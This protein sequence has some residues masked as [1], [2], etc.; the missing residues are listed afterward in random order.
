MLSPSVRDFVLYCSDNNVISFDTEK[1]YTLKSGRVAPWFFNAGNLMQHA[2]WLSKIAKIFVHTLREQFADTSGRIDA[3][4]LYGA[5]YKGVPL[6]SVVATE[7]YL[8]TGHN[9]G[10][11]SH[12]KESKWHGSDT[13]RGLGM[14]VAWKKCIILDDVISAG[15]AFRNA[16]TDIENDGGEVVGFVFLIDREEVTGWA[17]KPLPW[18][19]RISAVTAAR[20]ENNI[21]V[22][23]SFTYSQV[24]EAVE[25]WILG[26]R[27]IAQ[28]LD[29]YHSD[30]GI[31]N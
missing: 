26:N 25:E 1:W 6:A 17:E 18:A 14:S 4:I 3:D 24:R 8:Q 29:T 27:K 30:Y 12:R 31:H 21:P 9:I 22:I 19:K 10:F 15:T 2:E 13:G 7:Y 16:V 5:A 20:E 11:S 23:G 28:A